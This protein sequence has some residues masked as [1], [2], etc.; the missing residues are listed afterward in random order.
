MTIPAV[1]LPN[2]GVRGGFAPTK[3]FK[4]DKDN[5]SSD[6]DYSIESSV[7]FYPTVD[8]RPPKVPQEKPH[9]KF[10]KDETKKDNLNNIFIPQGGHANK[11]DFNNYDDDIG[12]HPQP[13]QQPQRPQHPAANGA[14]PGYFNPDATKN[15]YHDYTNNNP[16]AEHN[17]HSTLDK[18]LF[19]VLGPNNQNLPPHIRIEQIL[20]HIQG[21]DHTNQGGALTHGQNLNFPFQAIAQPNGINYNQYGEHPHP[22]N[23]QGIAG[24]RPTGFTI[25]YIIHLERKIMEKVLY[26]CFVIITPF[27]YTHSI[28][29]FLMCLCGCVFFFYLK[30]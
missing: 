7:P 19:N 1:I 9:K 6:K 15:Q 8:G 14:G 18:Q 12:I 13:P 4:F 2:S 27:P 26:F 17:D 24:H 25:N 21:Q 28:H 20:Q 30:K 10:S 3:T 29:S 5:N 22:G 11:F 16:Y 23:E